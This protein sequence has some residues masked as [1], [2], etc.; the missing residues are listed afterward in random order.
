MPAHYSGA[1]IIRKKFRLSDLI[2]QQF[3]PID[4]LR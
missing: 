2:V 4:Q 3:M 1:D